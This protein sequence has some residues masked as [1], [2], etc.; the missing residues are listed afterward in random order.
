MK[1]LSHLT[2]HSTLA[3]LPT[4][5]FK[6]DENTL[7]EEIET[8]FSE[9][10]DLP[11]VMVTAND[12]IIG[13]LPRGRFFEWIGRPFGIELYL[14][15]P[16][17]VLVDAMIQD[18]NDR[19]ELDVYPTRC[20]L[21]S[22]MSS[23]EQ[24][25]EIA[26]GRPTF[27]AYEPIVVARV[28]RHWQLLDM[29]VLLQ[30]QSR[31][32]ELAKD[33]ANAANQAK[34]DFLASMSH[35]LRTPLNAILGFTQVMNRD[36][37]LLGTHRQHLSI[38]S[39]AGEHLLDLIGDVLDMSKI[40]SGR[41][42]LNPT[43][44]DL[45]HLLD[46]LY[47]MLQL[48]AATKGLH[49][50]FECGASVPQYAR[51][52]AGKLRQVLI[53]LLGNAIKFTDT[54]RVTLRV[55]AMDDSIS[56]PQSASPP[57]SN[58]QQQMLR[59][60]VEDTGAGIAPE[61]MDRLFVPFRQTKLGRNSGTGTGLGLTIAQHFVGL[62]GGQIRARSTLGSGTNFTFEIAMESVPAAEIPAPLETRKAIALAPEQPE[63][64]ILV[65]DDSPE[66]RLVLVELLT[67]LGFSVRE[68]QNGRE[69]V[70]LRSSYA[71]HL[72]L[73]DMQ[74]PVMDGLEAT[75]S[76]KSQPQEPVTAI[77]A[78]TASSF[79]GERQAL[80]AAGCDDFLAKPFREAV[81]LDTI[82]RHLGVCYL[83]EE[84]E[85]DRCQCQT[86]PTLVLED[87]SLHL[88]LSQMP[89]D[90]IEDLHQAALKCRDDVILE[91]VKCIPESDAELA[92]FLQLWANDFLFERIIELIQAKSSTSSQES[93]L[94]LKTR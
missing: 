84:N 63:C 44:C 86:A 18:L 14:Q 20:L 23:I 59:V 67:S 37:K 57:T 39:R 61:E 47:E 56:T 9:C 1:Q 89:S 6:V 48:K 15:R 46:N 85:N 29:Y 21:L 24:A 68:A 35:E 81:L 13:I 22:E 65:A 49:L 4:S 70:K 3:D 93:I 42:T 17:R 76:I 62:M 5:D 75:Q 27:L 19:L 10:P 90:W 78:L 40:E 43:N 83:Y 88:S 38:I 11:G 74:M 66:S 45:Y 53:N 92:S 28:D 41:T 36:P 71:P 16:I 72:I 87:R 51:I 64:R 25:V 55:R 52:D 69:A 77:V 54:G 34:S 60:E 58:S 50:I 91:L 2:L 82:A 30:A 32:F 26:L 8:A 12:R 31:Q 73:M 80:L 33:A 79:D 7:G 94:E